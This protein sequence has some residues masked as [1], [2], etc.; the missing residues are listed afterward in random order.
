MSSSIDK[1]PFQLNKERFRDLM[2]DL[3][4]LIRVG[5]KICSDVILKILIV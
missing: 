3:I 4:T 1:G 5:G 2:K